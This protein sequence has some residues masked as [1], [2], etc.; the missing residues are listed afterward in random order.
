MEFKVYLNKD[1]VFDIDFDWD[2]SKLKDN[3]KLNK[4]HLFARGI[5]AMQNG[6]IKDYFYKRITEYATISGKQNEGAIL[7]TA[8][9]TNMQNY[10]K[11]KESDDD[12][13]IFSALETFLV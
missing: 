6:V 9:Q 7:L 8:L 3:E 13:P 4:I 10:N 1:G 5:A 11:V 12:Q 2:L